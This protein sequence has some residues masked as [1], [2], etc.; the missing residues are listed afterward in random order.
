[1]NLGDRDLFESWRLMLAVI[2]GIYAT[3]VTLRSLWEWLVYF[4]APDRS[5]QL[6][7][8]YVVL[9]LL[10]LRWSRFSKQWLMIGFYLLA[11]VFLLYWH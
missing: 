1:M 7:K 11:L 6:M 3:V 10:R 9:H 2:C 4:A 8:R 5:T